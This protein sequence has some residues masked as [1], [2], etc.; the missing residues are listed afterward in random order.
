[1]TKL[2]AALATLICT[3]ALAAPAAAQSAEALAGHWTGIVNEPGSIPQY[4]LSV[5]INLDRDGRPVGVVQYDAFPC[6]GVWSNGAHSGG[7]WTFDETIVADIPNCAEHVTVEL[8]PHGD[9]LQVR[10]G[11][12]DLTSAGELRRRP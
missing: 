4:T 7:V 6:A 9:V 2:L 1:M 8:R 11:S 12:S 3:A 10:L 5:H